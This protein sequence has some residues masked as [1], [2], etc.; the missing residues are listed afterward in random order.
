MAGATG[1]G[2]TMASV[3][4]LVAIVVAVWSPISGPSVA[5]E[6]APPAGPTAIAVPYLGTA[7]IEPAEGWQVADCSVPTAA[8]P[9]V[10]AC[11]PD[12]IE[13]AASSYDPDAGATTV[14][15]PLSNG[16][17]SM[18]FDYL[19]TLDP[20]EPPSVGR[21]RSMS[22]VAA[23]SVVLLPISDLGIECTVCAEGGALDVVA[24]EPRNAGTAV[25]TPTHVVFRPARGF[26]GEA[27]IIVRYADDYG[28]W[29]H[30]A[31]VTVPVYR[32]GPEPLIALSVF[33][34][35]ADGAT[36]V[37]LSSL[38]VSIGGS[39]VHVVGCGA[40]MH[41]AVV[42]GPDGAAMYTP[43]GEV[44]V[45]QFSFQ[46]AASNG[47]QATGSVTLVSGAS[48]SATSDLPESG[49]VP[50]SAVDEGDDG[51]PSQVVPALP[52]EHE[53][54]AREGVFAALIGTLDRAG[55]R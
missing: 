45:D 40:P 21:G 14:P 49:P 32:G 22:P 52:A 7:T 54:Q 41:G 10:V 44:G 9:L 36:T 20:P 39:D 8:T 31:T 43:V 51:V 16:R 11:H 42:C 17:T 18:V 19:V 24:V 25:A 29:S 47:E 15:V 28:T 50:A 37:D 5:A 1:Q 2:I 46:V 27:G 55:A 34:P 35:R 3:G 53:E 38:A 4:V 13:L 48:A 30:D 6:P 12:R 33:A 26:T 23:G